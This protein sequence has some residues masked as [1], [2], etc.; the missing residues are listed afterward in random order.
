MNLD[1]NNRTARIQRDLERLI[2]RL[3]KAIRDYGHKLASDES[4]EMF[5]ADVAFEASARLKVTRAIAH[6]L[7]EQALAD[8]IE[9]AERMVLHRALYPCQSTSALKNYAE[10]RE[11][12]AWAEMLKQLR[13]GCIR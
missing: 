9:M 1:D 7:S 11:T 12:V 2:T 13:E 5:H 6:D 10:E 8:V 4:T 3:T